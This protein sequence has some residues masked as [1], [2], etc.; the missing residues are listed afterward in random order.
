MRERLVEHLKGIITIKTDP[1]SCVWGRKQSISCWRQS[2][3]IELKV[4]HFWCQEKWL[5]FGEF[6]LSGFRLVIQV[7]YNKSWWVSEL[8]LLSVLAFILYL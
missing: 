2:R 1:V 8:K 3:L 4:Q 7:N 5:K 6:L